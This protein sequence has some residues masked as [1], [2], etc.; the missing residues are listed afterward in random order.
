[1]PLFDRHNRPCDFEEI[2]EEA[3]NIWSY[4]EGICEI[5]HDD[6]GVVLIGPGGTALMHLFATVDAA[7]K[8]AHELAKEPD[9]MK[10][11]LLKRHGKAPRSFVVYKR[12]NR[13]VTMTSPFYSTQ[14]LPTPSE[15]ESS[16]EIRKELSSPIEFD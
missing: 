3:Q 9:N 8:A 12:R 1:M 13:G 15:E 4:E 11:K 5:F 7:A 2:H 16:N 14:A 10:F 6:T